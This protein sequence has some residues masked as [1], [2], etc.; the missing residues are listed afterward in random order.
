MLLI[1]LFPSL[2]SVIFMRL[3]WLLLLESSPC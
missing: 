3:D 1:K 2:D